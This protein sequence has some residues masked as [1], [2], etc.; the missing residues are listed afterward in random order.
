[1]LSM[2]EHHNLYH[3][4]GTLEEILSLLN[5]AGREYKGLFL[6]VHSGFDSKKCRDIQEKKNY[7]QY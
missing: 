6:N 3:I 2:G 7:R 4:E 1:M 5:E